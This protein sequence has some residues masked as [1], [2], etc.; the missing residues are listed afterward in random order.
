MSISVSKIK[1]GKASNCNA[2]KSKIGKLGKASNCNASDSNDND[3]NNNQRSLLVE[4]SVRVS[5]ACPARLA[6][7]LLVVRTKVHVLRGLNP[8]RYVLLEFGPKILTPVYC[9]ALKIC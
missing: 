6:M 2:I 9:V 5:I 3:N 8:P 4:S 7:E 1:L